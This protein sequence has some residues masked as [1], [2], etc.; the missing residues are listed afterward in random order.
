MAT[1]GPGNDKLKAATTQVAHN[2]QLGN[3]TNHKKFNEIHLNRVKK[4]STE[5]G[6]S[7]GGS[8]GSG[9][10]RGV[11]VCQ[12]GREA[13]PKHWTAAKAFYTL[14]PFAN[15]NTGSSSSRSRSRRSRDRGRSRS[16][17]AGAQG[18]GER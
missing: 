12:A 9:R 1:I 14:I 3:G 11:E 5:R 6:V 15:K 10:G 2:F 8:G 18:Q 17:Q 7:S 4:N 13:G 16:R